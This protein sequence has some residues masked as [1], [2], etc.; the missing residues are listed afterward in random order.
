MS[1]G[2]TGPRLA[3]LF[4]FLE[5]EDTLDFARRARRVLVAK[6]VPG[7]PAQSGSSPAQEA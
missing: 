4:A 2:H 6:G 7:T 5:P 1:T 3:V